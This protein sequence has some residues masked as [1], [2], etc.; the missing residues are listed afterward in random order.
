MIRPIVPKQNKKVILIFVLCSRSL[1]APSN[2]PEPVGKG[3]GGRW[4]GG[5]W[6]GGGGG[7]GGGGGWGGG[8]GPRGVGPCCLIL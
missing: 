8:G 6:R 7:G 4:R 2:T 1:S 3:R 5:R